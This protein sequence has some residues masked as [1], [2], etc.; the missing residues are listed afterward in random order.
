MTKMLNRICMVAVG[1]LVMALMC[2][3]SVS[4]KDIMVSGQ[5]IQAALDEARSSSEQVTVIIPAGNYNL[6]SSLL[7]YP[8]T[9]IVAADNAVITVSGGKPALTHSQYIDPTN[10]TVSGGTWKSDAEYVVYFWR[11]SGNK[12]LEN[13]ITLENMHISGTANSVGIQL[14]DIKGGKVATCTIDSAKIGINLYYSDE[15]EVSDNTINDSS[16]T[17]INAN[18][19][20]GLKILKNH[21]NRS[22]KFG[23]WINMDKS[24][25]VQDNVLDGCALDP[26]PVI[27]IVSGDSI[28]HGE[29]LVVQNSEG[30][31][32]QD[33]EIRDVKSHLKDWGNGVI[34]NNSKSIVVQGNTVNHAGNH[35]MQASYAS[36]HVF[37]NDNK[38]YNSGND[39]ISVSRGSNADMTGNIINGTKGSAIVYDGKD[40]DGK[41]G[42]VS[43]IVTDC[44]V[45]GCTESGIHI[46]LADVT[47]KKSEVKNSTGTGV[48]VLN[49]T[50]KLENNLIQQDKV[51][52]AENGIVLNKGAKVT[53]EKN[54]ISN[55]G[56]SGI[57][58]NPGC[59]ISGT[60]NQIMVNANKFVSNSIFINN[61]LYEGIK[62][63]TLK[64]VEISS[65]D[66]TG[67]THWADF[68]CGAVV[69]GEE[70]TSRSSANGGRFTVSYPQTD[71]NK[72]VVYV[73]DDAGNAT[74]LQAPIGFDLNNI[75]GVD[76][77]ERTKL[78]EDLIRRMY[79]T[80]LGRE[81]EALG[82][83]YYVDKLTSGEMDGSAMAQGF[84]SSPEFQNKKYSEEEYLAALYDA[85]FGR[86]P[87]P[88][89][90]Q[91]WKNE[92]AS[93][94]SRKYVLRGFVNSNEYERLCQAAGI[95]RGEMVL[96][97]GE[98]YEIDRE[99][100]G[101]FV[102]RLYVKA[103]KRPTLPAK[104][105][106]RYYVEAIA[107]REMTAEQAAKNFFF[108]PEF[109]NQNTSNEEYI[110]RLYL[111][112]MGREAEPAGMGYWL[113]QMSRGMSREEVLGQFAISDEFKGIM[114]SYGIR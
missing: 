78:M 65:T 49:S 98:E 101:G 74:I 77:V 114:E 83:Q 95:T 86:V 106:K 110:G 75:Q 26:T 93:G 51:N 103:L 30:T 23:I 33:N 68:E 60:D 17:G 102:E 88:S 113:D 91:Y 69:N 5:N 14:Q 44:K 18:L 72:V 64:I 8:N 109:K 73:K 28:K 108:S 11:P 22:G 19:I 89:E 43:G 53:L 27:D 10:I 45:D 9:K 50:A 84:A 16:V 4:A 107:N 85:F 99:K 46:E 41:P 24:S 71:S 96:G 56:N 40:Y 12:A 67:Q 34:V 13:N 32:V 58:A 6:G 3:G 94:K 81:A 35:G 80:M 62:N 21:V 37:F 36:S 79:R 100:L 59:S 48:T 25:V 15:I 105:E 76:P 47:I 61:A 39:G 55:F 29:G 31:W 70:Y 112:F 90:V 52:Q 97:E 57:I 92:M 104:E 20:N 66:V 42:K 2:K 1:I 87:G 54:R 38:V 82:V 63:N 111:T 7:V